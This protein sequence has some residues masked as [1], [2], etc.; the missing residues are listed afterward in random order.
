MNSLVPFIQQSPYMSLP[1][2]PR[3]QKN[4]RKRHSDNPI[5]PELVRNEVWTHPGLKAKERSDKNCLHDFCQ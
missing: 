5:D 2:V 3:G 4:Q 1:E